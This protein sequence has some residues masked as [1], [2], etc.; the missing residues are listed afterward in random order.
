MLHKISGSGMSLCALL[1]LCS[2]CSAQG[3]RAA[4]IE[5]V[6]SALNQGKIRASE[7]ALKTQIAMPAA[8]RLAHFASVFSRLSHEAPEVAPTD[9]LSME[10]GGDDNS[11]LARVN[12]P[13]TDLAFSPFAGYTQNTTS[14]ARCGEQVVVGFNDSRSILS[15]LFSGNGGISFSGVAVSHD[16]GESFRDLGAVPAGSNPAAFLLGEPS[17]ACADEDTFFYAQT[18]TNTNEFGFLSE[19]VALSTSTNGGFTWSDPVVVAGPLSSSD[20]VDD[21]RIAVDPSNHKKIYISY[22]HL[23]FSG[24][25]NC[26]SLETTIELVSSNNGG[27]SFGAPTVLDDQCFINS[28]FLHVGSRIAVASTGTVYVASELYTLFPGLFA[29]AVQVNAMQPNGSVSPA[30]MVS[31]VTQSGTDLLE[32]TFGFGSGASTEYTV[33]GGFRNL[34]GFDLAVDRSRT[35]SNGTVYVVWDDGRDK[36]IPEFE[37]FDDGTYEFSD[38]FISSSVN[39]GQTFSAAAKVNSDMQPVDGRGFD[40]F[41]PAAAVNSRGILAVCWYDRRNDPQNFQFERFCSESVNQGQSWAEFRIKGSRSTPSRGQD[42][43]LPRDD[44]G[45]YDGLTADFLD[46]HHSFVDAF[47][48]MSSGMNPDV[49]VHTF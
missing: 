32:S 25:A 40:H 23:G 19:A 20:A 17:V 43:L 29:Q 28:F 38:V 6:R 41:Q 22:R 36:S 2:I 48:W 14:T 15:T 12:D 31:P 33:Q 30:V 8:A 39:G 44:M 16:G 45:Q 18:F 5:A 49:R 27:Q 4:R 13:R 10:D 9:F 37:S 34:R 26:A 7:L 42:L 46:H 3:D 21:A 1:L 11:G 35:K 47:Q 24:S